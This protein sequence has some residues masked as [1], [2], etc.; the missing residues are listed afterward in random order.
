MC[1]FINQNVFEIKMGKKLV[2]G[3]LS[4]GA[5]RLQ[6]KYVLCKEVNQRLGGSIFDWYAAKGKLSRL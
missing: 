2:A 3:N 5:I 1:R 6:Y 4:K